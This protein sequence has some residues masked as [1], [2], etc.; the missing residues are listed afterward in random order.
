[1]PPVTTPHPTEQTLVAY[2]LGKIA[3]ADADAVARHLEACA[4]CRGR[5]AGLSADSFVGKLRAGNRPG[6][7]VVTESSR[8]AAAPR[9]TPDPPAV[10]AELLALA[11]YADLKEL[12]RGGMGVVYL[13]RNVKMARLEVL[14]VV[15]R[16]SLERAG[17]GAVARFLQEIQSAAR[18]NHPNV[19]GAYAVLEPGDLLVFAMEYA[20]GHDLAQVV[21]LRG[22]LPV[23]VACSYVQSAALGLQHA[24]EADMVHRN[25]KPG[26]LILTTIHG[27]P[28]VKVL[29]F[30][31]AK[32]TT[33]D[34][35]GGDLTG[36]GKMM[37]TP[38]FMAPEQAVDASRAD[39][40]ADVYS[41]GCTLYYLLTGK[42]PFGGGTL[43]QVIDKHRFTEA[44]LLNLVQPAVPVELA[45]AVAKMMAKD[46]ARRY[47]TPLE[48]VKAMRPFLSQPATRPQPPPAAPKPSAADTS[49]PAATAP[50]RPAPAAAPAD[51]AS[52]DWGTMTAPAPH[53]T[54]TTP[55]RRP[56]W[57]WLA[58][59]GGLLALGL[60]GVSLSGVFVKTPDGTIVLED[61]PAD[62]TVEVDGAAVTVTRNGD[63]ATF[64]ARPG[65]HSLKV[66]QGG[67]EL[68]T[69]DAVV[70]VGGKSFTAKVEPAKPDAKPPAA[71]RPEPTK[72]SEPPA[73]S[74]R[75]VATADGFVPLFNGKDLTGWEMSREKDGGGNIFDGVLT[76]MSAS[77][78]CWFSTVRSNY[79]DYHLQAEVRS[80]DNTNRKLH[81]RAARNSEPFGSYLFD[82]GGNTNERTTRNLGEPRIRPTGD[83]AENTQ[84]GLVVL[85]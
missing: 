84:D 74:G 38:D 21:K 50:E 60:A 16:S 36:D 75:E 25:I 7:V 58:V 72:P 2:G 20:P 57:L 41:L 40:R 34:R 23:P 81:F 1:M 77:K 4:A 85:T 17:A 14:K 64:T 30:G 35:A 83:R 61:L 22:P 78:A 33:G 55:A 51:P 6:V 10:P 56:R 12:G 62:A 65:K 52:A 45:A 42:P 69:N 79:A 82:L 9:P 8:V 47:A 13:A 46:P 59:A 32:V 70:T 43:M 28:A 76:L 63:K 37:G 71:L 24:H 18:L 15:Q 27:R 66:T 26:N 48:V 39:I 67:K 44:M 29:D 31:L 54:R 19:V 5:V 53:A 73:V 80:T 68:L 49:R 11:Q 3:D